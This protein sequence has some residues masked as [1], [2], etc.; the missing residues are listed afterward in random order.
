M[1]RLKH[2][3]RVPTA[4]SILF[5]IFALSLSGCATFEDNFPGSSLSQDNF[6]PWDSPEQQ[7]A[8]GQA[9]YRSTEEIA[10]PLSADEKAVLAS[11][12]T[13]IGMAPESAVKVNGRTFVLDCIGTV[14]AIFYG[15]DI[16]VQ[17]DFPRYRG[18]GVG[19]LYQSLA[20]QRALHRDLYPRAGDIIFWD[21]TWD[22]NG[23]GILDNDPRTHA[24]V[25]L[26]V[27]ADGTIHYVHE[28]VVKGV[29]VEAMNL[30]HP[31]DYYG[32]QGRIINNALAMN[33]GISRRNNPP[34][35]TS[36]DLWDS[37][38]DILRVQDH[39]A[40]AADPSGS[41]RTVDVRLAVK[42]PDQ[43]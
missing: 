7:R 2:P 24:G 21:N 19:R 18:D 28:H 10:R 17:R 25:V 39:F 43:P 11:A 15:L 32:P 4:L 37:F 12:Q 30:L 34:H 5:G 8:D 1:T 29:T 23:D 33:S 3:G 6:P 13:L 9:P 14:S 31:R 16:D 41:D 22:A 35:W 20:A 38:G 36:G 27:D 42:P 40:V 26:S